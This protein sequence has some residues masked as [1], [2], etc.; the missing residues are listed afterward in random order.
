MKG[1]IIYQTYRIINDKAFIYLY[2]R[3]ENNQSFLTISQFNPYFFI[4]T[5]YLN[6]SKRLS[7]LEDK[8]TDLTNLTN[9][10]KEKVTKITLNFPQEVPKLRS[11]FEEEGIECYEADIRFSQR[12]L[13]D[14]KIQGSLNIE[15]DYELGQDIDRI[16]KEP[17]LSPVRYNPDNLKIISLDIETS[18]DGKKL[19]C[20]S[21]YSDKY[22]KSFIVSKRKFKN[23]ISC[24]DEETLLENFQKALILEDPDIITGWNVIDF[25][26]NFLKKKFK[27]HHIPYILGRDN[28]QTKLHIQS[29]FFR[30]SKADV[31]GRQVLDGLSLLKTSFIKVKDYKLETVALNILGKKKLIAQEDKTKIDIIYKED[32]EHLLKYNLLDAQL[33][34]E[35]LNKSKILE[36]TIL[37]SLLTG[38][39]LDKVSASI[40]SFDSLYLKKAR[41]RKLVCPSGKFSEKPSPI[42]GGYVMESKPGIYN[43]ILVLDF[44][45]LYPSVMSTFN[46][47][48][49]SFL[50]KKKEKNSIKSPNNVYFRNE[51]GI[52]PEIIKTLLEER[53]KARKQKNELARYSIKILLNSFF[54]IMASPSCR[55]FNMDFANAI[56]HFGQHILKLTKKKIEEINFEVIYQDT[57]S[58]FINTNTTSETKANKIGKEIESYINK[59]YKDH[60]KKE[61][62][63]ES[64]LE[65]EFEKNYIRFLMPKTRSGE[66][67]A[68][69]RYAGLLKINEKEK[70]DIVGMEA[71]R[72][73]WTEA[74]Q[75]FQKEIL[76]RIF[77]KKE[78]SNFV[79]KFINDINKG[80]YDEKLVYRK[81]IR[82]ELEKY[83]KITP[84]HVK[85]ARQ[86]DKLES[87]IIEYY[88]T[89][90][91][92]EPKQL[93]KHK[94]DYDHYINKQIKPLAET[95][96]TFFNLNF[97][98]LIKGSKQVSLFSYNE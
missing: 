51:Q 52:V 1:F 77:H 70:I 91:G 58:C 3:L 63:R 57:D 14:K 94:L 86:L 11:L 37:R 24:P 75:I 85:A 97:D 93:L 54:G 48:P 5:K 23:A 6:R 95:V 81:Q 34:Y 33:V 50:G 71:K 16:Y 67:G 10:Q 13:I 68:K 69:K 29:N 42:T 79:K 74:A 32:P 38:M 35:I 55:F 73:D 30:D 47:D 46:I 20:I 31:T 18:L 84:P 98:D 9:F 40:A 76:N 72:A 61:Y 65:L 28:T 96:L 56:T 22:Q 88:I 25:D 78:I 53:E 90:N 12:F 83:V 92:P 8:Q 39:P 64:F 82:K 21:L 45:S 7:N 87:N 19:Y 4:K 44:K 62:K 17:D 89:T 27:E 59:F 41:D 66:K 26:L 15:G 80:K 2:G 60:I 36:L 49:A 43:N